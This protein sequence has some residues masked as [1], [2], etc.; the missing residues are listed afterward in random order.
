VVLAGLDKEKKKQ[1]WGMAYDVEHLTSKPEAPSS[2]PSTTHTH[3]HTHKG[4]AES[5]P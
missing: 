3:T 4:W 2:N 5:S 1:D